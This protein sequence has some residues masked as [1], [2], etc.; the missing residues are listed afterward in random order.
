MELPLFLIGYGSIGGKKIDLPCSGEERWIKCSLN[1]PGFFFFFPLLLLQCRYRR[2]AFIFGFPD[3]S[4]DLLITLFE[5][6][7]GV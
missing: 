3:L 2:V 5:T 6:A 4:L 7:L 1:T